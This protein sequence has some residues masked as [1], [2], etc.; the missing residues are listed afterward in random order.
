M[1]NIFTLLKFLLC[2]KAVC[3]YFSL[4]GVRSEYIAQWVSALRNSERSDLTP[5]PWQLKNIVELSWSLW[6]KVVIILRHHF[7]YN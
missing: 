1:N 3:T 2:K 5:L 4:C 6:F 7:G